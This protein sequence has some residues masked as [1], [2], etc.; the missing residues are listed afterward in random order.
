[1]NKVAIVGRITRDVESRN[2]DGGNMIARF[3][4][5]VNR[6]FKNSEGNYDADFINCVAFSKTAEFISKYFKK[7][8]AIGIIGRI[9]TGKYTNNEGSTVYTTDIVVDEAEFVE[10]K[11]NNE[12]NIDNKNSNEEFDA[13]NDS[14]PDF[15]FA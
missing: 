9:Q 15:P 7:G 14:E 10:G 1:M 2:N 11:S 4:V 5:A 13:L 8:S 6:R 3:T 12:Q